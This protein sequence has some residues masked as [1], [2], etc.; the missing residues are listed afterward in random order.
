MEISGREACRRLYEAHLVSRDQARRALA[1]GLAGA[2]RRTTGSLRY[3][4]D[5]VDALIARPRCSDDVLDRWRPFIARIGR[6]RSFE[7]DRPW[8]EQAEV[9]AGGWYIPVATDILLTDHSALAEGEIR[10]PFVAVL[11]G[12]VVFGAE[13]VGRGP[14]PGFSGPV[15]RNRRHG[16]TRFELAPPCAWFESLAG[17]WLPL[18][19]GPAW[20][21]WGAPTRPLWSA[22]S[23]RADFDAETAAEAERRRLASTAELRSV[24]QQ[25]A[26]PRGVIQRDA[27]QQG[28]VPSADPGRDSPASASTVRGESTLPR[29]ERSPQQDRGHGARLDE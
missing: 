11:A 8:A 18:E 15:T 25:G 29:A 27:M 10:H 20:T 7:V 26:A 24:M 9:L 1:A 14:D 13:I 6:D 19:I 17:T 23:L 16:T 28:P 12:W 21:L 2:P 22:D 3:D 5:A 4:A